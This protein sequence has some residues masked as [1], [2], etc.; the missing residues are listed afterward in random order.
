[1]PAPLWTSRYHHKKDFA[2][3]A[4]LAFSFKK[5]CLPSAKAK[6]LSREGLLK[7]LNIFDQERVFPRIQRGRDMP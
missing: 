5:A 4:T 7:K 2:P 1:M 6:Y 3:L